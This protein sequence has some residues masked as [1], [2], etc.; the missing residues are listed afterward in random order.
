MRLFKRNI[1]VISLL[2]YAVAGLSVSALSAEREACLLCGMYLP[3]YTHVKYTVFDTEGRSYVTCGVQCGLILTLNLKDKFQ[4]ATMTDLFSH[5]TIASEKGWY[6]F[7]SSVITDMSPGLLGFAR[8]S[9]A[10]KF[11]KGFGGELLTYQQALDKAV[12][13]YR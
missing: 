8:K 10:E 4:S 5:K 3:E 2:L 7:K 6:V 9:Q 1:L 13:G 11:I 12:T